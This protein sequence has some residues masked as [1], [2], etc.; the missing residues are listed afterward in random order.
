MMEENI[1]KAGPY[2]TSED[3]I[4]FWFKKCKKTSQAKWKAQAKKAGMP[5][6]KY[7]SDH[8]VRWYVEDWAYAGYPR[9]LK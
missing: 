2:I 1:H 3:D 9:M 7:M 6:I 8:V 5:L 4:R